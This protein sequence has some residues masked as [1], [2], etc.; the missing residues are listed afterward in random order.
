MQVSLQFINFRDSFLMTYLC[1]TEGEQYLC[2][3]R[4]PPA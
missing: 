3:M 4:Y 2:E 1:L